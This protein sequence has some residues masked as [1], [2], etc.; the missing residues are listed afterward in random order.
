MLYFHSIGRLGRICQRSRG[1][2]A[3]FAGG[4][5]PLALSQ[6]VEG[7]PDSRWPLHKS[8][9][10]CKRE[11]AGHLAGGGALR[12]PSSPPCQKGPSVGRWQRRRPLSQPCVERR[13]SLPSNVDGFPS[14]PLQKE[15]NRPSAS[16]QRCPSLLLSALRPCAEGKGDLPAGTRRRY[17][18]S[19]FPSPCAGRGR[20]PNRQQRLLLSSFSTRVEK[21]ERRISPRAALSRSLPV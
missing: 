16:R 14:F 11:R 9:P 3:F 4:R 10:L 13:R 2:A 18:F 21:R 1:G 19:P 12:S 15:E 8:A 5:G 6:G 7:L 20:R 17:L